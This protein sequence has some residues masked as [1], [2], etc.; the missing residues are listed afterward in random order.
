MSFLECDGAYAVQDG[1]EEVS[2]SDVERSGATRDAPVVSTAM[3]LPLAID[4]SHTPPVEVFPV[5]EFPPESEAN[6]MPFF[7]ARILALLLAL[8]AVVLVPAAQAADAAAPTEVSYQSGPE[9][10]HALL[11]TPAGDT[12]RESIRPSS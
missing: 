3:H 12:G 1:R 5:S 6:A 8:A 7:A 9:T 4:A 11:Y 2:E 10:V